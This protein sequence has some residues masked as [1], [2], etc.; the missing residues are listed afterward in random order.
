[1]DT[2]EERRAA[3]NASSRRSYAKNRDLINQRRRE[4]YKQRKSQKNENSL[5]PLDS[6]QGAHP[7]E[8]E[9]NIGHPRTQRYTPL[10]GA[11]DQI[12]RLS[13]RFGIL[14]QGSIQRHADILYQEYQRSVT[15]DRPQD[16]R[17]LLD[18]AVLELSSLEQSLL[19][20]ERVILTWGCT[21]GEMES[22]RAVLDPVRV[23]AGWLEEMLC[24]A[25]ISPANLREKYLRREL[26]FLEYD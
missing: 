19:E 25:M 3:H 21:V 20:Q 15:V 6:L 14:T 4:T 26:A 24:E 17:G 1:M 2:A 23:L 8:I 7:F 13:A 9:A 18:D 10:T 12:I 16:F 22:L 11:V 5:E